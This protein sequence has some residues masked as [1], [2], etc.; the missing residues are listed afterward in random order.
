[1]NPK[2]NSCKK[3]IL[4]QDRIVIKITK[5]D[6]VYTEYH[7]GG[8]FREADDTRKIELLQAQ[9]CLLKAQQEIGSERILSYI[10]KYEA[11]L[12]I[13]EDNKRLFKAL[14]YFKMHMMLMAIKFNFKSELSSYI[15]DT[16]DQVDQILRSSDVPLS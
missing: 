8:C 6:S 15:Q 2:C 7:C 14:E 10:S 13:E 16:K 11:L 12:H 3:E 9:I 5:Y 1:M 4:D